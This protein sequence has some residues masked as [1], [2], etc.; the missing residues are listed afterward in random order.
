MKTPDNNICFKNREQVLN[1]FDAVIYGSDLALVQSQTAWLNDAIIHFY[2]NVL[3]QRQKKK[4]KRN[5]L[6]MD[7]SIISF[8]MHQ[9]ID[10]DDIN[11]EIHLF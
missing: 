1:F 11:G 3:D 4:G 8:F 5:C 9:V 2:F 6:F 7:P 10:E